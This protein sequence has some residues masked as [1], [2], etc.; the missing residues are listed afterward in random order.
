MPAPT[1]AAAAAPPPKEAPPVTLESVEQKVARAKTT[2][3]LVEC[4][5]A[6]DNVRAGPPPSPTRRR[7]PAP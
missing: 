5:T 2:R 1:R 4:R 3:D 6:L 7:A